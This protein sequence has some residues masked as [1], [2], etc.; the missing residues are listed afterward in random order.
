MFGIEAHMKKKPPQSI[1][2][3]DFFIVFQLNLYDLIFYE[4]IE[5]VFL[6]DFS[7]LFYMLLVKC[8]AHDGSESLVSTAK[9]SINK[10]HIFG[11]G[12][13]MIQ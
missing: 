3:F 10:R 12:I 4:I 5:F 2:F 8:V 13:C 7:S 1:L 6:N 11:M 9:L